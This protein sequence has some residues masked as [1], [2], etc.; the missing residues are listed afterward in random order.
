MIFGF[1]LL[2]LFVMVTLSLAICTTVCALS[3]EAAV[4]FTPAFLFLFPTLI[5]GFPQISP[6]EAIGLALTI[7]IFG[8]TSSVA[9][10]WFRRQI[11]FTIAGKALVFTMPLAALARLVSY[12][13]PARGLLLAFGFVLIGLAAILYRAHRRSKASRMDYHPKIYLFKSSNPRRSSAFHPGKLDRLILFVGGAFAGLVGIAIGEIS[14]TL[15]TVRKQIP[16]KISIGTSALI[17]HLTILSALVTNLLILNVA[18]A[19]FQA[20]QIVIPWRV[21]AIIAPVVVVGGQIGALLN[22]R[23]KGP[24]IVWALI[25]AYMLV[26]FLVLGRTLLR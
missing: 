19:A 23:L 16:V 26:G 24:T 6:N 14:N 1:G 15:L 7:E 5:L 4:L 17:L 18:P 9:G 10:Y 22:N 11:D 20:E 12:F 25:V 8:Y 3:M 2:G 21:A 13:M